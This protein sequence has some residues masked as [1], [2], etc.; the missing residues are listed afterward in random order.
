MCSKLILI[1]KNSVILL[2]LQ[3][4]TINF[5]L[6]LQKV[7]VFFLLISCS[8]YKPRHFQ[9]TVLT[10]VLKGNLNPKQILSSREER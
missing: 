6:E 9:D 1:S 10:I 2:S 8:S 4:F 7:L 5:H 3:N